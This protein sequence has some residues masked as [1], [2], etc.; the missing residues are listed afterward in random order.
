MSIKVPY[1]PPLPDIIQDVN[2]KRDPEST[3][4]KAI[5]MVHTMITK[6]SHQMM[7]ERKIVIR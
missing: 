1:L 3:V 6:I 7:E 2:A 5:G 4:V